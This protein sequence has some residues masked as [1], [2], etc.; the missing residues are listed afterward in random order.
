MTDRTKAIYLEHIERNLQWAEQSKQ[1][2]AEE[3]KQSNDEEK[4]K[5]YELVARLYDCVAYHFRREKMEL[6]LCSMEREIKFAEIEELDD[7]ERYIVYDG[8]TYE[9]I[10][11]EKQS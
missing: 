1:I 9:R 7:A 3:A 5:Q 11:N 6:K 8:H 2:Y 4:R 10:D